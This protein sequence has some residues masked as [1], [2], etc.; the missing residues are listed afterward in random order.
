MPKRYLKDGDGFP[1]EIYG[2]DRR[3]KDCRA[4][5]PGREPSDAGP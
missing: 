3:Y 2:I 1:E 4:K 5:D